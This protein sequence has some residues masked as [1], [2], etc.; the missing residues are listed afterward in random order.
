MVVVL[1]AG[2]W[3]GLVDRVSFLV[4]W[5]LVVSGAVRFLMDFEVLVYRCEW[6]CGFFSVKS[7]GSGIS[8]KLSRLF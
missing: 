7:L 2:G 3:D 1:G 4:C 8:V 6:C 5:D